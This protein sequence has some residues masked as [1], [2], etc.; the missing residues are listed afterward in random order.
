MSRTATITIE[1]TVFEGWKEVEVSRSLDDAAASFSLEVTEKD[2]GVTFAAARISPGDGCTVHLDGILAVTGF[3]DV[4]QR[5]FSSSDHGVSVSG[6]SKTADLVDATPDVQGGQFQGYDVAAV[7]GAVAEGFEAEV[8]VELDE[9][10]PIEDVQTWPGETAFRTIERLAR[11]QGGIVTDDPSGRLVVKRIDP[12]APP[13]AALV[14]GQNIL[15]ASATFRADKRHSEVIVK[16]QRPGTDEA[17]A[18]DAA[19]LEARVIDPAVRRHRPLVIIAEEPGDQAALRRRADWEVAQRAAEAVEAQVSVVGWTYAPGALWTPGD[20]VRLTSPMLA[21]DSVL[22]IKKATY[23]QT[24]KGGTITSMTL[25][26]P[27]AL[28]TKPAK[29][30]GQAQGRGRDGQSFALSD[31]WNLSKPV[32]PAR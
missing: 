5:E 27:E 1:G 7:S 10:E 13:V 18:E 22:V 9:S 25:C 16:G 19:Q 14:E 32:E 26:P 21:V 6:R 3:V 29:P 2:F 20:A 28:T 12:D 23:T 17:F 30:A 8:S 31:N 15:A 24:V 4:V 11:Q